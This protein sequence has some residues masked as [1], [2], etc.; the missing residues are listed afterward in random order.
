M[1]S[2]SSRGQ[3]ERQ[4][5]LANENGLIHSRGL[6]GGLW[7]LNPSYRGSIGFNRI[8]NSIFLPRGPFPLEGRVALSFLVH[9]HTGAGI[10]TDC[11][12]TVSWCVVVITV[13]LVIFFYGYGNGRHHSH[14]KLQT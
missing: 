2:P 1:G 5:F 8:R 4:I 13:N 11:F 9:P 6:C 7:F 12:S 3:Q 10:K 14:A